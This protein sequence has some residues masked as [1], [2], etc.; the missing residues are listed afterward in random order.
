MHFGFVIDSLDIELCDI[1]LLD[2][3]LDLSDTDIPRYHKH[4]VC[5]QD[6]LETS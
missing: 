1:D 3:D 5:L 6:V 2:T 4:F